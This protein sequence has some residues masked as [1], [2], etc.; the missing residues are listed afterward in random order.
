MSEEFCN[1]YKREI[2]D[3]EIEKEKWIEEEI[4]ESNNN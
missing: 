4:K 3:K 1:D 2:V